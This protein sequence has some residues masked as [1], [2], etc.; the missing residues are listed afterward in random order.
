MLRENTSKAKSTYYANKYK[1]DEI[2]KGTL[3]LQ[4]FTKIYLLIAEDIKRRT[5]E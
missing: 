4:S 1:I 5:K 3:D 2:T